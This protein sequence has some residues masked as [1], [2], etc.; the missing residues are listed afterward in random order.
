MGFEV[1]LTDIR[2]E[3]PL[4][5]GE[6]LLDKD[7][8][9]LYVGSKDFNLS[10]DGGAEIAV[11]CRFIPIPPKRAFVSIQ[12][13]SNLNIGVVAR[14]I[15]VP[16]YK[17]TISVQDKSNIDISAKDKFSELNRHSASVSIEDRSNII[18]EGSGKIVT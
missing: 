15:P 10:K 12:D 16:T 11:M 2:G 8:N 14:V 17:A 9:V 6:F 5:V 7:D 13:R 18:L 4:Q 3:P 1:R